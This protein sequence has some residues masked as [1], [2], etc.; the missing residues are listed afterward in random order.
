MYESLLLFCHLFKYLPSKCLPTFVSLLIFITSVH[1]TPTP[2][3][4]THKY[5]INFFK[6]QAQIK[7]QS[8]WD[9]TNWDLESG[10]PQSSVTGIAH[11]QDGRLWVSTFAGLT[12][13][14]GIQFEAITHEMFQL[15]NPE[16][17]RVSLKNPDFYP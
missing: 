14:D 1:A 7:K 5:P 6:N 15:E 12:R 9:Q 8:S 16:D 13:F 17:T 11:S 4:S 2:T 3:H 10:L